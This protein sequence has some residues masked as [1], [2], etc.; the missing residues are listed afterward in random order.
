[1]NQAGAGIMKLAATPL[2]MSGRRMIGST[3]LDLLLNRRD[4]AG[5]GPLQHQR[6]RPSHPVDPPE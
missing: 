5:E 2:E 4:D 1:M 6:L 3:S